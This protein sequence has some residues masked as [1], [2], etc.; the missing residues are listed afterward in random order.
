MPNHDALALARR[1]EFIA[2]SAGCTLRTAA[3]VDGYPILVVTTPALAHAPGVYLSAGIHGDEPAG[4]AA[5]VSWAETLG[6]DLAQLPALIFPCLNP[7]G[8]VANTRHDAAGLDLNRSFQRLRHPVIRAVRAAAAPHQFLAAAM[9]HEDYDATGHYAYEL[10]GPRPPWSPRVVEAG[11]TVMQRDHRT[12]I[13]G[14][15]ARNGVIR[16]KF[17]PELFEEIGLPEAVWFHREHHPRSLTLET[18]SEAAI[19]TRIHAH[20]AMLGTFLDLA[21]P[22]AR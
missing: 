14:H 3:L 19:E 8:L 9:L 15:R 16:R 12:R 2:R 18:P 13:D 10:I 20:L 4:P 21:L 5:L 22:K 17:R 11:E 6:R 1:W 7:A